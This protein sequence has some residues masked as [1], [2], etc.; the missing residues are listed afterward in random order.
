MPYMIY[1][2]SRAVIH[3]SLQKAQASLKMLSNSYRDFEGRILRVI[4]E[5]IQV[6]EGDA[7]I[8]NRDFGALIG[9]GLLKMMPTKQIRI[10]VEKDDYDEH[11][12]RVTISDGV[13]S[14]TGGGRYLVDAITMAMD[15]LEKEADKISVAV[16]PAV[17]QPER[18][19]INISGLSLKK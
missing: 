15:R 12:F 11:T 10:D 17:P 6:T 8:S 4:D 1:W 14:S 19:K 2:P 16:V 5:N 7:L 18:P 3:K 13:S 9:E